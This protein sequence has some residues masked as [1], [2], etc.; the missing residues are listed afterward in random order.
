LHK[1]IARVLF[2]SALLLISIVA[3]LPLTVAHAQPPA[4][5]F[6]STSGSDSSGTGSATSP[7][8][9]ISHAVAV[10][11]A[12]AEILVMPGTYNEM[13]NFSKPLDVISVSGEPTNTI[14]NAAGLAHGIEIL[15]AGASGSGVE[16]LTVE[17]ANQ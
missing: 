12:G 2:L 11:P 8:A 9:T 10:A 4:V 15:G 14:I 5:I 6:V 1:K 3:A 17:N 7:Y 16:G 13:V